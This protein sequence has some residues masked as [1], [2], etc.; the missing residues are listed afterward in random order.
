MPGLERIDVVATDHVIAG[1]F[2]E[3]IH[4]L[5]PGIEEVRFDREPRSMPVLVVPSSDEILH[6]PRDREEEV[7]DFARLVKGLVR[8]GQL[9]TPARAALVVQKRLPY[10][11]VA[12]EIFRAAGVPC[13]S[14]LRI[15]SSQLSTTSGRPRR[16]SN[17][18]AVWRARV[19]GE[20]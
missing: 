19:I 9:E 12:R 7:A 18:A 17:G 13:Q 6:R 8:A 4:Q 20:T 3:A 5:L 14:G 2:H 10:V 16:A 11:Y 1:A 15:S